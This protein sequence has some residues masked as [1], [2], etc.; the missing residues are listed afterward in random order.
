MPSDSIRYLSGTER[1]LH[2]HE[3]LGCMYVVDLVSAL[4]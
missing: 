3:Y 2:D 4:A 1:A